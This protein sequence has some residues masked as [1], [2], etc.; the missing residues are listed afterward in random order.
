VVWEVYSYCDENKI[1]YGNIKHSDGASRL[2]LGL[3]GFRSCLGLEGYRSPH[4]LLSWDFEYRKKTAKQNARNSKNNQLRSNGDI[5]LKISAKSA[6]F[7]VSR[8]DLEF[9]VSGLGP[10][11]FEISVSKVTVSTTSLIK[12]MK[13]AILLMKK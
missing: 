6:N 10:G 7:E 5:F 11:I 4:S 2:G 8:L 1:K 9:Q 13:N 12:Y 3:Q